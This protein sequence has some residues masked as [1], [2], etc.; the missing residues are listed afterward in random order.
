MAHSRLSYLS[1]SLV[2]GVAA[3][4]LVASVLGKIAVRRETPLLGALALALSPSAIA[5][6]GVAESY[7]LCT[8]FL[9]A[10]TRAYLG[11]IG[12]APEAG[13]GRSAAAFAVSASLA[14]LSHYAAGLFLLAAA[15]APLV[16][17]VLEPGYR[18]AWK[19]ASAA[20]AAAAFL[21]PLAVGA[22]LFLFLARPWMHRL[23]HVDA[24]YFSPERE[25]IAAYLGRALAGTFDLFSPVGA[26]TSRVGAAA[27]VAF[28]AAVAAIAV[29]DDRRRGG[30]GP[31][32][33]TPA[34][35]LALLVGIEA[36]AGVAGRYPF[37]GTMRHQFLLLLFGLLAGAVAFDRILAALP[38]GARGA[39]VAL[40]V[41]AIPANAWAHLD[42]RWRPRPEPFAAERERFDRNF[43]DAAEIHVDQF[44]LVAFFAQHHDGKWEFLGT[45]E[46]HPTAQ[47][48]RVSSDGR[49]LELVAHR[50]VWNFDP[51]SPETYRTI[52]ET[53]SAPSSS[54]ATL[55]A[56]H[57]SLPG[58]SPP[59]ADALR[60]TVPALARGAG[61]ET[62]KLAIDGGVFAE[63]RRAAPAAPTP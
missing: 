14:L 17:A 46:G 27:L 58:E 26:G 12:P 61:L 28:L 20:W 37:G 1:I 6:S 49:N 40:A 21:V 13:R 45:V 42:H 34:V 63:F 7:M 39:L 16:L 41:A 47:R 31:P 56:I 29:R 59:D 52:A 60:R 2:A 22:A 25:T 51:S 24:F 3:V 19:R 8:A 57:Q 23:S 10:A 9:L 36:A 55:F 53:P 35:L 62:R 32:A 4:V 18:R 30:A 43:P 44:N 15:A 33:A 48:Y 38:R 54:A 50:D 11:L 5:L